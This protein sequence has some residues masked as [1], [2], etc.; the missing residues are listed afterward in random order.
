MS[1]RH[2]GQHG[3]LPKDLLCDAA[4]LLRG[5]PTGV[6][7]MKVVNS[8]LQLQAAHS[9]SEKQVR[10]EQVQVWVGERSRVISAEDDRLMSAEALSSAALFDRQQRLIE[11]VVIFP[12]VI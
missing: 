12:R 9:Y 6:S 2:T 5:V 8:G 10:R 4:D 7:G 1:H 3:T 11:D